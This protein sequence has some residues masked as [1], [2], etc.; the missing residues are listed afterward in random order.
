MEDE[1]VSPFS[2]R[3]RTSRT[4]HAAQVIATEVLG[5]GIGVDV[6]ITSSTLLTVPPLT[7]AQLSEILGRLRAGG[8]Q[9]EVYSED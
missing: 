2:V 4:G 1:E 5:T 6:G 3:I 7:Q 8:A 9:A